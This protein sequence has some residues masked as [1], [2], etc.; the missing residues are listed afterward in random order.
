MTR[1]E[2]ASAANVPVSVVRTL[3]HGG[4]VPVHALSRIAV[5]L[6]ANLLDL[7]ENPSVEPVTLGATWDRRKVVCV[8]MDARLHVIGVWSH[9][10][11]RESDGRARETRV[12]SIIASATAELG[13]VRVV[14]E[15]RGHVLP[16][17]F[18][19]ADRLS[20]ETVMDELGLPR[21]LAALAEHL[22]T[23]P[24]LRPRLGPN[25]RAAL[26]TPDGRR[27]LRPLL[28]AAGV[29]YAVARRL[30]VHAGT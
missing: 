19:H 7:V 3:E 30:V 20:L 25:P 26:K 2:L 10:L 18:A 8:A 24:E 17:S 6:D 9:G 13:S 16:V 15:E 1:A 5:V 11:R 23:C 12:L 28:G 27:V 22:G 4:P 21:S 14:V 29:A